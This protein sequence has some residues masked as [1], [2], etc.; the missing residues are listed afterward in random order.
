MNVLV[1]ASRKGG[2]GKSTL[3]AHLAS[4]ANRPGNRALLIDADPQGS[5][6][7][8]HQL[9]GESAPALRRGTRGMAEALSAAK[10]EGAE[11]VFIDTPP[12]RSSAVADAIRLATLVLIPARPSVFDLDAVRDTIELARELHK[13]Y[14]VVMNAAPAKRNGTE[15]A[16]VT[17]A[18]R[19]V[20]KM[21]APLWSG[22]ITHRADFALA[23]AVGEGAREFDADS[24]AAT[25]IT[26]LWSAVNRSVKA[27]N[28]AH[29]A[30]QGTRRMAA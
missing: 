6:A 11:W 1:F 8:W 21:G 2:S 26:Q 18:R 14:A 3:A 10:S 4:C 22:Q 5:L 20:E 29:K 28:G 13:P 16:I 30:A 12:N 9:R 23:L 19:V 27:I 15:S 24:S 25:E 7:L 17:D